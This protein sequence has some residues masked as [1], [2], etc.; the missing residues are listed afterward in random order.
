MFR[1]P[2]S[3]EKFSFNPLGS[4]STFW[5]WLLDSWNVIDVNEQGNPVHHTG[6]RILGFRYDIWKVTPNNLKKNCR[7]LG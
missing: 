7:I 6:V 1:V 3:T 2:Y 4:T 5:T